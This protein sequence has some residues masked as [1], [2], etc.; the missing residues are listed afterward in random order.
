MDFEYIIA[1]PTGNITVLITSPYTDSSRQDMISESFK[2]VP[3]CEQVGFIMP[4]SDTL[5][6]LEM[7]GY[8]FCGNATLSAA[9]YQAGMNGL[10]SGCE[11]VIT[12]ESSGADKPLDV[13][14]RRLPGSDTG[15]I[16]DGQGFEGTVSMPV[17]AVSSFRGWP[18]VQFEGISH[19]I[20]PSQ[21]FS[22]ASAEEAVKEF[23]RELDVPALGMML[24]PDD[25]DDISFRPLVYVPGSDTLFWEHGC[26]TGSTAIGFYRYHTTGITHTQIKQP[27]GIIR[28]DIAGGQPLL[29]G[30]VKFRPGI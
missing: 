29:T 17:P 7:M 2:R 20:V 3:S 15:S 21:A 13:K 27:G 14:V 28:V 11:A 9:A 22:D 18:L 1:D 25:T 26:A 5:I 23:A 16:Y 10:G 30:N 4:V 24:Q 6:R 8:E 19:L 12:V